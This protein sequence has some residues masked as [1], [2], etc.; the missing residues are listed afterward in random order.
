MRGLTPTGPIK[1]W[2]R[3]VDELQLDRYEPVLGGSVWLHRYEGVVPTGCGCSPSW[4][5]NWTK[6]D[7]KIL[8]VEVCCTNVW[9]ALYDVRH[10][11]KGVQT[12]K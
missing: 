3:P 9:E 4:S 1:D 5:K 10:R 7:L 11:I 2:L 12:I 8:D 6:L